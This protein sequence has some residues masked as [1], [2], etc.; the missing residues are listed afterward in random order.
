MNMENDKK[1]QLSR[2]A[3]YLIVGIAIALSV[4]VIAVTILAFLTD[5]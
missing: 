3:Q 1:D 4:L 5:V 2:P